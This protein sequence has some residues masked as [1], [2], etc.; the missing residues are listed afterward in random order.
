MAGFFIS[1]KGFHLIMG[2]G[3]SREQ[4]QRENAAFQQQQAAITE[5][6]QPTAAELWRDAQV[7]A[8]GDYIAAGD[9]TRAP[10][11]AVTS[12][13]LAGVTQRKRNEALN[14]PALG[15][16][17]LGGGGQS[18]ALALNRQYLDNKSEQESLSLIHI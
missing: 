1:P 11:G 15:N 13:A 9:F 5:A 10:P 12:N 7:K 14:A 8:R 3:N 18:T 4:Q 2:K 17:A 16:T 6:R